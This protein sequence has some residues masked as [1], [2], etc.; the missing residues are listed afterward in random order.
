[1]RCKACNQQLS[2]YETT[3]KTKESL[4]VDLCNSCFRDCYLEDEYQSR[5]DLA[6]EADMV[7]PVTSA[8]A[9]LEDEQL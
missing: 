7:Y 3:R 2:D 9:L 8:A 6:S 5:L 4:Y 1:M